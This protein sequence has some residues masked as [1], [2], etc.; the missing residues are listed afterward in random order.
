[1]ETNMGRFSG[2]RRRLFQALSGL[3]GGGPLAALSPPAE[4]KDASDLPPPK[5]ALTG[6]NANGKSVFKSFAVPSKV[7][8]IESNPGLSFYEIYRTE[9]LP[10]LTGQEP[11]PMLQGTTAFAGPGGTVFRLVSYPPRRPEGYKPPPGVTFESGLKELSEKVPGMGDHFD[12]SAPGMHTT[13]RIDYCVVVRG[14]MTL[15]LDDGQKVHL[16][17]GERVVQDGTCHAW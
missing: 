17:Q 12:R 10:Q 7:V 5:R 6:R 11:D 13:D 3:A 16:R 15:E 14:E 4:A 9:G 1:M 2:A 8:D